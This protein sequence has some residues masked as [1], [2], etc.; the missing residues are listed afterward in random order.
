MTGATSKMSRVRLG[1]HPTELL[2]QAGEQG[3]GQREVP[4]LV[5]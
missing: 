1:T 5:H 4:L 3:R 2:G